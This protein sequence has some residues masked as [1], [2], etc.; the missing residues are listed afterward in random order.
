MELTEVNPDHLTISD[1]NERRE[2]V[3]TSKLRKSVEEQGVLQPPLV[4]QNGSGETYEVVAGQ[5]RVLAAQEAGLEA[6]PVLIADWDDQEAIRASITENFESFRNDVSSRDRAK[7][8]LR[9]AE[10][11]DENGDDDAFRDDGYPSPSWVADQLGAKRQ[12]VSDWV[13]RLR[14]EWRNT[15][16]DVR[17]VSE[18]TG[19]GRQSEKVQEIGGATLRDVRTATGGGEAGEE[20]AAEVSSGDLSRAD[21]KEI[22]R[23]SVV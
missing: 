20:I 14:P 12:T 22:D 19:D 21:V 9:M 6:V 17:N 11:A 5:R 10:L 8:I 18:N 1:L 7:A 23:K 13:E 15:E 3:D 4:R 16:Y 2:N